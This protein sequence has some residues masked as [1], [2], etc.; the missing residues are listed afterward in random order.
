MPG[1]HTQSERSELWQ[2]AFGQPEIDPTRLAA[3]LQQEA[4]H[5]DL[6]SRTRVLIRD[7]LEALRAHWG[8]EKFGHWLTESSVRGQLQEI[9]ETER[10]EVGFTTLARRL[11]DATKR[12]TI[13]QLFREL[14]SSLH[15]PQ[16]I[17]VG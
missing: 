3:A 4:M 12:E 10:A 13:E 1:A 14:G 5:H 9:R 16:D 8:D 2:L 6:D 17:Y 11:M 15:Q 7:G